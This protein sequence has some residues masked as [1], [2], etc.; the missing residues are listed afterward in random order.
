MTIV[1][2]LDWNGSFCWVSNP[3]VSHLFAFNINLSKINVI[4][5]NLYQSQFTWTQLRDNLPSV[6]IVYWSV[7][8]NYFGSL[9]RI[10]IK[11][12]PICWLLKRFI[13]INMLRDEKFLTNLR[14][15]NFLF[16]N[17]SVIHTWFKLKINRWISR[18]SFLI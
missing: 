2:D 16:T 15:R 9:F 14:K 6:I 1:S 4:G 18:Y 11:I 5:R 12:L 8:E 10:F 13:I 17:F 3:K 7:W